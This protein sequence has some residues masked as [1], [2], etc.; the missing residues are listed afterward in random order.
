MQLELL[1]PVRVLMAD[2]EIAVRPPKARAVLCVL[3]LRTGRVVTVNELA[4]ALWGEDPP[5]SAGK[6]LQTYIVALRRQLP[7]GSIDTV[8]KGYR[9][10]LPADAVDVPLFE[11]LAAR[12]RELAQRQEPQNAERP[13]RAALD[14]WRGPPLPDLD[15]QPVGM[16]EVARLEELRR[17]VEDDLNDVQLAVGRHVEAVPELEASVAAEPLRE[18]RWAQLMLALY[19]CGRQS[20][21]LRAYSRLRVT[22]GDELGIEPSAELAAL[23]EAILLQ[24]THLDYVEPDPDIGLDPADVIGPYSPLEVDLARDAGRVPPRLAAA[25]NQVFVGREHESELL[26]AAFE[27]AKGGQ[28]QVVLL[29]GEAGIGKTTLASR[30]AADAAAEG[31]VV[32][33]GDAA[34][35]TGPPYRL[36]VNALA[37]VFDASPLDEQLP[38]EHSRADPETERYLLISR[39]VR[40]VTAAASER[41]VVFVLEDLHWADSA[42][43]EMVRQLVER[44]STEKLLV[45]GTHRTS[46]TGVDHPLG[47]LLTVLYG[48]PGVTRAAVDGLDLDEVST[49]I[50]LTSDRP[51]PD[52]RDDLAAALHHETA[53][54]PF[55]T[56]EVLRHL[57]E[58]GAILDDRSGDISLGR[59]GS[60]SRLPDGVKDVISSR[61]ARLGPSVTQALRV[62]SVIGDEFD[63]SVVGPVSG[64]A[65]RELLETLERAG[66]AGLIVE[67]PEGPPGRYRFRHPITSRAVYEQ[68]GPARRSHLHLE[69]AEAFEHQG[70]DA[71]GDLTRLASHWIRAPR[72]VAREKA[73]YY[74]RLAADSLLDDLAPEEA[75][76]WYERALSVSEE[77]PA[78]D[79]HE[80]GSV[81]I[82]LGVAQRQSGDRSYRGT[83]ERAAQIA[84]DSDDADLLVRAVLADS[85]G[86]YSAAGV[87]DRGRTERL[88]QALEAIGPEVSARRARLIANLAVELTFEHNPRPRQQLSDDALAVARQLDDPATLLHVLLQRQTAIRF[89]ET[90]QVRRAEAAEAVALARELSHLT[91]THNAAGYQAI[92]ALESGDRETI[93]RA[94]AEMTAISS[95]VGRPW[96]RIVS[97]WNL[98]WQATLNGDLDLAEELATEA[99]ELGRTSGQP[100][101]AT[102]FGAQLLDLR[103][104]QGRLDE[105]IEPLSAAIAANPGIPVLEV[106][107]IHALVETGDL[108][109]AEARFDAAAARGF[110][111]LPHDHTWLTGMGTYAALASEFGN[112]ENAAVLYRHLEPWAGQVATT[113]IN[114]G[115]PIQIS[116]CELATTLGRFDD[117]DRHAAG[118]AVTSERL[119]SPF[120]LARA[121]LAAARASIERGGPGDRD[122]GTSIAAEVG[123]LCDEHGWD[124]IG[125]RAQRLLTETSAAAARPAP[126]A[127]VG[128]PAPP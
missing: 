29:E 32:L 127:S 106:A 90:L 73:L 99:F 48:Q 60:I 91:L 22:L 116:L 122:R 24:K 69:V 41:P 95:Q 52:T 59:R 71:T 62:A 84:G 27:A 89:P 12:G 75:A 68:L 85:R 93:D 124:G 55:F 126:S 17:N 123:A 35:S 26:H 113:G 10:N 4:S 9:L 67:P 58:T 8:G 125:R 13:L 14:L 72:P 37:E 11:R 103:M 49:L 110:T 21:A 57:V 45:I 118:A 63:M 18:R 114:P 101:A 54:N 115:A 15:E 120:M 80:I 30:L 96:M 70:L 50:A 47:R 100:E 76:T 39:M 1:G 77:P 105:V 86:F 2:A 33:L 31:A 87:V 20:D 88:R 64:I 74:S 94:I 19:R 102:V 46:P 109:G 16:A 34:D 36:F 121:R 43:L 38:R 98:T 92:V 82:G 128:R 83:L 104:A 66:D 40:V 6:T 108:A 111:E 51:S 61:L 3:G 5:R 65:D 81:L 53:G 117:A 25:A 112:V 44:T 119:R 23:E 28:R 7:V 107:Y 42:S 56:L 79:P 97:I 78:S